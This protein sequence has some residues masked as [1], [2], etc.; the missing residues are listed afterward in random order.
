MPLHSWEIF[1]PDS[2]KIETTLNQL[3]PPTTRKTCSK[4]VQVL[5]L[6]DSSSANMAQFHVALQIETHFE[7]EVA[8]EKRGGHCE[9]REGGFFEK[10]TLRIVSK[11]EPLV[12]LGLRKKQTHLLGKSRR[13]NLSTNQN[14]HDNNP[15]VTSSCRRSTRLFVSLIQRL[16]LEAGPHMS[17]SLMWKTR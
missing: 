11:S 2:L 14:C 8:A 4:D 6:R 9:N 12:S 1:S 16:G 5:S 7:Q 15:N 3:S 17:L 10:E 13:N